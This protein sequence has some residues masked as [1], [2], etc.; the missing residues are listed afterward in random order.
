M[1]TP[2]T[3]LDTKT[4]TMAAVFHDRYGAPFRL[5]RRAR[6]SPGPDE[7]LVRVA[8]AAVHVGDLMMARG[9]P[10]IVRAFSGWLRPRLGIPGLDLAG[11]VEA[12][13]VDVTS[14]R[15]GDA[16][17]GLGEGSCA[18]LALAKQGQLAPLPAGLPASAAAGLVTSGLAALHALRD[19]AGVKSGDEVLINGA[20]G[21]VGSF[22][23][24]LARISGARVTGVCGPR[25]LERVRAL[26]AERVVD[27]SRED[28]TRLGP[29]FA[30]VLDNVENR[31]L[32]ACRKLLRPDG[33]LVL[34]SGTGAS[35][36]RFYAR[37]FA[38]LLLDPF[39][40]HRLRR[41]ASTPNRADLELLAEHA[42]AGRLETVVDRIFPLARTAEALR[43]VASGHARGKV[44]IEVGGAN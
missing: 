25:N 34:N 36:L 16:V 35:G 37:L 33:T 14:F 6:P 44:L 32:G 31:P 20:S 42:C 4:D 29:R 13:G 10:L 26:G 38:P 23:V 40:G 39:V 41:Y 19:V 7:V 27:Y 11:T 30:L 12:V 21:G 3:P 22:A 15:P 9:A 1:P 43:H 24:Q 5:G 28:F 18:A 17:F 2:K 8:F